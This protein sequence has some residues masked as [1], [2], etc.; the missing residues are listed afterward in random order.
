M[1]VTRLFRAIAGPLSLCGWLSLWLVAVLSL[2]V[3]AAPSFAQGQ[4]ATLERILVEGNQRIEA[5]TVRSYMSLGRGDI[6]TPARVDRSL[7]ALF[8]TGLFSDVLIRQAGADLIVSVVENPIINQLA[9]EGNLRIDDEALSAEVQLRPRVVFTRTRIQNDVQRIIQVYRRGGRFAATV[10]PKV[11]QLPQNRVDL[12]FEINEGPLTGIRRISFIG[13]KRYSD[14]DLRSELATKETR[15]YRFLSSSDNYDPDR[16]AFDQELIRRYYGNRGYADARVVSAVAE[17]SPDRSHFFI[18]FTI[19]EGEEFRIDEVTVD[20]SVPDLTPIQ[21]TSTV[22]IARGNRFSAEAVEETIQDLTFEIGRLGYAFVDVRPRL[23]LDRDDNTIDIVFEINEGPRV[24]VERINITGNVRTLDKV[25]R[26]EF[27]VV[28]GDAFNTAR[29]RRSQQRIRSLGFFESVELSDEPGSAPDKSIINV[30]VAERSTGELLFGIGFSTTD[31]LIGDITI[32]ERN[33]LGKGQ[34][35]RA[36]FQLSARTQEIDLSFNEPFFLD[37]N[38]AAGFDVFRRTANNQA[39]S[40]FD[41]REIGFA[42]RAGYPLTERLRQRFSYSLRF[43]EVENVGSDASRFIVAGSNVTSAV[44]HSLIYDLRDN[45]F[46]PTSGYLVRLDQ[47]LAGFGGNKSFLDNRLTYAYFQPILEDWVG[48]VRLTEGY[49]VGLGQG[50]DIN[51]RFFVGGNNFRG[52]RTGG[53]GPR[54]TVSGDALGGNVFYVGTAELR[55]PLGLPGELGIVGRAFS[56]AGSLTG[57][58]ETG[59]NLFDVGSV[60][61]SSGVGVSWSSPVG[62]ISLDYATVL[63]KEA[64]DETQAFSFRFA[65]QF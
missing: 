15:F 62:P 13:N 1:F 58:D 33:L 14:R 21:L 11:I 51:D 45:S 42:V 50:V 7:K 29:L 20:S 64:F 17:L 57:I 9:F 2:G 38:V 16:L 60:R 22:A 28:E 40:S 39:Q 52:F 63:R 43:D 4:A 37:R 31:K 3:P 65:T 49:I 34:D 44:G 23:V 8:A 53:I 24:Y 27:R 12:V 6:V 19:E 32:R 56:Q 30:N 26:R 18:T 41:K 35:L 10:E 46:Q 5:E 59:S 61:V 54:D 25:V 55:F 48:S 36:S 47:T